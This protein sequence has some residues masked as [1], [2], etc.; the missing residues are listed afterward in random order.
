MS[1]NAVYYRNHK[2]LLNWATEDASSSDAAKSP[3]RKVGG[4]RSETII[5]ENCIVQSLKNI[6]KPR[7]VNDISN[8]TPN[9][10][11]SSDII[12]R[13]KHLN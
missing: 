7:V 10:A 12:N 9:K 13:V 8:Y 11:R 3:Q 4:E 1:V 6:G 5:L 2:K